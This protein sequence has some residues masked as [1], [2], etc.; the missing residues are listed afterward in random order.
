MA[1][2]INLP[3]C[4]TKLLEYL[5]P[6][7]DWTRVGFFSGLP[8]YTSLT[9]PNTIAITLPDP[10]SNGAFRIYLGANT[11]FC[12]SAHIS[13]LVHE[14][15]HIHQFM[16]VGGGYGP[17][18]FRPGF[19]DYFTCLFHHGYENNP[20]EIQANKYESIFRSRYSAVGG[21]ATCECSSGTP[22]FNPSG[23]E[24][25]DKS[26]TSLVV[27]DIKPPKCE[28]WWAPILASALVAVLAGI[29]I[30]GHL[31]DPANCTLIKKSQKSCG[32]WAEMIRKHCK[33]TMEAMVTSCKE[34]GEAVR[35]ECKEKADKGS[36]K[37]TQWGTNATSSCC[38]WWPCSWGCKALVWIYETV[39]VAT[40]WISN[41]VCIVWTRIVET[42]CKVVATSVIL[43]CLIWSYTAQLICLFWTFTI[44]LVL[45]CW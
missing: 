11:D 3:Q 29:A 13:T 7:V 19:I 41:W 8:W 31:F 37:C 40:A 18:F 23:L 16:S 33:T 42:V 44:R 5:Y 2:L 20:F 9:S 26:P 1:T 30:L 14:A 4:A 6:T 38:T 22:E 35:D 32:K 10:M 43:I 12:D 27:K 17:G 25:L 15:F 21:V 39:C 28:S 45:F 34:W 36:S 24:W